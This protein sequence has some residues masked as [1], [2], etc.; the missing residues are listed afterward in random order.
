M[1]PVW[2][3]TVTFLCCASRGGTQQRKSTDGARTKR[4]FTA[5]AV[6]RQKNARQSLD[7]AVRHRL[8]RTAIIS[9][10]RA[11]PL[12][13]H[14]NHCPLPCTSIKNARQTFSKRIKKEQW[15]RSRPPRAPPRPPPRRGPTALVLHCVG[16]PPRRSSTEPGLH[17][18]GHTPATSARVLAGRAGS[19]HAERGGGPPDLLRSSTSAWAM[20]NRM[21][22]SLQWGWKRGG[23]SSST[24]SRSS[25]PTVGV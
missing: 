16:L 5:F 19:Y 14:G 20:Q 15:R 18:A 3:H 21:K 6:H 7:S 22:P 10:C 4:R 17:H 25:M 23:C 24:S 2:Q 8:K 11:P 9:L 13:A 12:K 1:C